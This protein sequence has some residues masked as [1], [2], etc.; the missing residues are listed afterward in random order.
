MPHPLHRPAGAGLALLA[1]VL[2]PAAMSAQQT[3]ANTPPAPAAGA[4]TPPPAQAAAGARASAAAAVVADASGFQIRSSDGAF[5]LKLKGGVQFDSRS[6]LGDDADQY[7]DAFSLRRVRTD[8][9]GTL[10]DAYGFRVNVELANSKLEVLD[11]FGEA[12][13]TPSFRLRVGKTK[14]PVGLERLQSPFAITFAEFGAPTALVPNRDVGVMAEGEAAKGIVS[15]AGGAFNGTPDGASEDVDYSDGKD[16]V[17]RVFLRPFRTGW[18][19]DLGVGVAATTG[20]QRGTLAATGLPTLRTAGRGLI[21]KYRSD[22]TAANTVLAD[23]RHTR[24]I[25]QGYLYTGPLGF[26]GE[27]VRSTSEVRRGTA[28]GTVRDQAWQAAGTVVLTGEHPGYAGVQPAR[29]FRPGHGGTGA[30]E[31]AFRV[32]DLSVGAGAFPTFSDPAT[33]SSG[34]RSYTAGVNW[35]VNRD[36]RLLANYQDTRFRGTPTPRDDERMLVARVQLAF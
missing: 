35:Y 9:Q 19:K 12:R 28:T 15:Y 24:V 7:V 6:F 29:P 20:N 13:L 10:F 27:W 23:G 3:P 33:S 1:C 17:G 36:V 21:M 31:L 5:A 4:Q 30:W 18:L 11:A 16:L 34:A 22:A 2:L 14:P 8:F 25:P 26:M 32:D